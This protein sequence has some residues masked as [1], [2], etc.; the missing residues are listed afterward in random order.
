VTVL[1]ESMGVDACGLTSDL[2]PKSLED[3]AVNELRE[4]GFPEEDGVFTCPG[5]E[6]DDHSLQFDPTERRPFTGLNYCVNRIL[7]CAEHGSTIDACV[8][9]RERCTTATPWDGLDPAGVDCYPENCL[10]EYLEDRSV[11]DSPSLAIA[12]F[13]NDGCYPGMG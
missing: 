2:K 7:F 8:N 9:G 5:S 11:G 13:V 12:G 10:L 3:V 1:A 4:L 6:I